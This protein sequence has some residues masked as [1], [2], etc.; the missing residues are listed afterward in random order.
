MLCP[1]YVHSCV[2]FCLVALFPVSGI[3]FSNNLQC[4]TYHHQ[5]IWLNSISGKGFTGHLKFYFLFYIFYNFPAFC[6]HHCLW[7][8]NCC[9]ITY[10]APIELI[11][12]C[13][14]RV[15]ST[16]LQKLVPTKFY[17]LDQEK[18]VQKQQTF[19]LI[20]SN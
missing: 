5:K 3:L 1:L 8:Q 12:F 17:K 20:L 13:Q 10:K 16:L 9:Q 15:Y 19:S 11:I 4:I 7:S 14:L 2:I 6:T 18:N